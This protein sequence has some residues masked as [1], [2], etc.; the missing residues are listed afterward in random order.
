MSPWE[1]SWNSIREPI[2]APED[3]PK[4]MDGQ[5]PWTRSWGVQN[6]A[7]PIQDNTSAK[8]TV[9]DVMPKLIQ[10]ESKGKHLDETGKL[11]T[12]PVGA[13][14]I[15]QLMPTTA[16]KPG[17]GIEPVKDNSEAEYMRVGKQYLQKMYDKFNDWEKALAAY[18]A[19]KGN[20]DAA[21]SKADRYGGDWKDYL[22]KKSETIPYINK[23]LG[24]GDKYSDNTRRPYVPPPGTET[25]TSGVRG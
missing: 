6:S 10:A 8:L 4:T 14:G 25:T 2:A 22:P 13:Q 24:K 9:E 1:Q 18:N 21:I 12:S 11:T 16:K 19:G 15:T 20:V 3:T 7:E 17:Y 23:I 5:L